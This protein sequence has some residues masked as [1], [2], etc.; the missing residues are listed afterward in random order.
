MKKDDFMLPHTLEV[1]FDDKSGE[2]W[3]N[4]W[5]NKSDKNNCTI[6][7]NYLFGNTLSENWIT[8]ILSNGVAYT[9]DDE[10]TNFLKY[11]FKEAA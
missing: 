7:K 3:M 1:H 5:D 11:K 2:K 10:I 8:G 9:T 6:L 4:N